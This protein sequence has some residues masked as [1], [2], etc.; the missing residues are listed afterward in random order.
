MKRGNAVWR[1][2]VETE[3]NKEKGWN[4]GV[5]GSPLLCKKPMVIRAR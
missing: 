1:D 2:K 5:Q 4:I 3:R